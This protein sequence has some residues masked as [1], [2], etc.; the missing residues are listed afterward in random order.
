MAHAQTQDIGDLGLT[1]RT[2]R[3]GG[4]GDL[5]MNQVE[6]AEHPLQLPAH[7]GESQLVVLDDGSGR[8]L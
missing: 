5:V 1:F 7:P 3:F 4:Y 2:S 6:S 8:G